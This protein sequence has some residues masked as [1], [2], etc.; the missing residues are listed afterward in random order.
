[1]R[2]KSLFWCRKLLELSCS[3]PSS[4]G[5]RRAFIPVRRAFRELSVCLVFRSVTAGYDRR[6]LARRQTRCTS[7]P[8]QPDV[9]AP[10]TPAHQ[11][12][13]PQDA[14]KTAT[15]TLPRDQHVLNSTMRYINAHT[16]YPGHTTASSGSGKAGTAVLAV[17]SGALAGACSGAPSCVMQSLER[18]LLSAV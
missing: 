16:S 8:A 10:A 4:T 18:S 14:G 1:M 6:D 7:T 12:A 13:V 9:E 15:R 3:L 11:T 17:M 2:E 5:R